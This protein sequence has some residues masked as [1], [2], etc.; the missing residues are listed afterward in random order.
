MNT[1]HELRFP[2][3]QPFETEGG[4]WRFDYN[5]TRHKKTLPI[6]SSVGLDNL[7]AKPET[8]SGIRE[9]LGQVTS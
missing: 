3:L 5:A 4:A 2:A 1:Y 7:S 8:Q 9:R 6:A